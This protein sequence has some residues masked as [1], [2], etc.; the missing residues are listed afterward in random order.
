MRPLIGD[1]VLNK[2][3]AWYRETR[4]IGTSLIDQG[5]MLLFQWGA[6]RPFDIAEPTD[7]RGIG[8]G[9]IKFL[10][11]KFQYLN[12]T[13]QV[14]ANYGDNAIEFDDVAVQMR[15]SLFYEPTTENELVFD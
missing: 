13:R 5:D 15:I 1:R 6:L 9:K 11:S 10:D 2:L 4:I 8:D 14:F 7:V 3:I 12:F